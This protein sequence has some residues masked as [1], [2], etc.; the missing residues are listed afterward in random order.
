MNLSPIAQATLLLTSYF[1]K[2]NTED[3]KPLSNAEWGR[4]ALW[5]KDKSIT[6]ADLLVSDPRPLLNGWRDT[7]VSIERIESLLSRGHSLALAVEKW[8]RAGLWLVTRSDPDYPK[9][10]K[11]RLKND[12]PP[13]LFGC[14]NKSLLNSGGLAVIGSRNASVA[15][16]A[17]TEQLGVKA[18]SEGIAIVSGGARGVD[19]AAMQ[20]AMLRGG[21]VIGVMADSLLKAATSAKWRKGLLENNVVLVSPFYPEAGFNAGNAM[22]RNKYI[23][24]MASSSLVI[25]SGKKGGTLNGAEENLKKG[26]VP[27]WV[28]PTNDTNAANADL[29][30]KGGA[31]I[32]SDLSMLQIAS[33]LQPNKQ[34]S[35]VSTPTQRNLFTTPDLPGIFDEL[36]TEEKTENV[37]AS[38]S[39][40]GVKND[41]VAQISEKE[42]S[43]DVNESIASHPVDFYN[44]FLGELYRLASSPIT[45]EELIE[46]T[47]LHKSQLNDWLKRASE[48]CVVKK[49]SKPVRYQV[50]NNN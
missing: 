5:L 10:L 24:C 26:W 3:V 28:K 38:D 2:A 40:M 39:M 44:I 36:E 4:F 41:E 32:E 30:E 22:A 18:A 17:F 49:L 31:W 8:Q 16:L 20:G 12:S 15:D 37:T 50:I 46:Q 42:Q 47:G 11:L 33:M 27:L 29:V 23:Y 14:G 7:R 21:S 25:H 13:V 43:E 45:L 6:P 48:E 9:R 1:S 35:L 34:N 19:E